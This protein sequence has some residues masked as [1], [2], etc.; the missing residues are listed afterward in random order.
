VQGAAAPLSKVLHDTA[1]VFMLEHVLT[2]SVLSHNL[3][4]GFHL[5]SYSISLSEPRALYSCFFRNCCLLAG[6]N[7][8]FFF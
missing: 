1:C 5:V 7:L 4:V 2:L 6:L 8:L 3:H